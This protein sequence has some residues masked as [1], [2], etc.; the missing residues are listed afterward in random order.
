MVLPFIHAFRSGETPSCP[1]IIHLQE[2]PWFTSI[3]AG[4]K[5]NPFIKIEAEIRECAGGDL[6]FTALAIFLSGGYFY[7]APVE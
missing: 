4:G 6:S 7:T 1:S 2:G 5:P 3:T